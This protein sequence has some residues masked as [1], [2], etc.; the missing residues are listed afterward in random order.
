[1]FMLIRLL[2][3]E[4]QIYCL[5]IYGFLLNVKKDFKSIYLRL[6]DLKISY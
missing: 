2:I 3:S 5:P 4:E 1:M 6:K